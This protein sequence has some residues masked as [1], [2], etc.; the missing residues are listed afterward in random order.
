VAIR[1]G[2]T[3]HRPRRSA[4]A[5]RAAALVLH[6]GT[7]VSLRPTRASATPA[8]R[9]LP[10]A[11]SLRRRG[12]RHGLAVWRLRYRVRGW[13]GDEMSPLADVR[14]ALDEIHARHGDVPVVLVGHS[15]GG[16]AAMR[17]AGGS[18]RTLVGLAPWVPAGE[19]VSQLGGCRVLVVHG[20]TDR[21]TSPQRSLEFAREASTV[22]ERIWY[23]ALRGSG[24]AMLRRARQWHRLTTDF[25]LASLGFASVPTVLVAADG[26]RLVERSL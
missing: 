21:R 11:W 3:L 24:H 17:S 23:V 7:E 2:P 13:N 22:A 1:T 4:R 5:A 20:S 6:G 16:R 12:R 18:A 10:F 26:E 19:P 8:V 25:V 15:M 9:M 14:H